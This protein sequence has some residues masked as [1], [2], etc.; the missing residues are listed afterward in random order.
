[1]VATSCQSTDYCAPREGPIFSILWALAFTR[2]VTTAEYLQPSDTAGLIRGLF[3]QPTST[4][5]PSLLIDV[6]DEPLRTSTRS[7]I[8]WSGRPVVALV[9]RSLAPPFAISKPTKSTAS[10]RKQG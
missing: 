5:G 3:S 4:Y 6:E 10:I 1:M 2:A 8:G 9:R 7:A